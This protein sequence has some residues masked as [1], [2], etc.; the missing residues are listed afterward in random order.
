MLPD[1]HKLLLKPT[2][3]RFPKYSPSRKL[4]SSL[5]YSYNCF[6]GPCL[7]LSVLSEVIVIDEWPD[8]IFL[9]S[10]LT[11]DKTEITLEN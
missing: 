10:F 2:L 3:I 7:V 5:I 11:A 4:F 8:Y 6:I 1:F 9:K